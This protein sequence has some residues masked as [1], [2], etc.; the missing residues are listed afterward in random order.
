MENIRTVMIPMPCS[1]KAYTIY[2]DDYY[3]IVLNSNLSYEQNMKSY[4]HEISHINRNDFNKKI[5][6]GM[7]EIK[8]HK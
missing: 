4:K 3:T 8:T 6:V 7:I 5:P 2:K 1:I